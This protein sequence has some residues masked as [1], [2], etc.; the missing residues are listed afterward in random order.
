[1]ACFL[2]GFHTYGLPRRVRSDKGGENVLVAEHTIK[3]R[4]PGRGSMITGPNTQNQRIERLS[5]VFDDVILL[6]TVF[7]NGRKCYTGSI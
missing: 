3:K 1:M 4:D 7:L 6:W 5:V 2:K